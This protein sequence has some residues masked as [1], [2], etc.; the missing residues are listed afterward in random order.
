MKYHRADRI[1]ESIKV[2][3]VCHLFTKKLTLDH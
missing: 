3:K 2:D 1:P